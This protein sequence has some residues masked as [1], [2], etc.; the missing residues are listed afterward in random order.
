MESRAHAL[1]AGIFVVLFGCAALFVLWWFGGEHEA[2]RQVTVVS[3]QAIN[4]L[5]PQA[6][7]RYRGVRIGKVN[8]IAF[9]RSR[10]GEIL[11]QLS[12]DDD[13]PLTDKT[14]A[15]LAFQGVT[16][17]AYIQLDDAPG[18]AQ[19][20]SGDSPRITLLPSLISE[21]IDTG[22]DT[23]R[24]VKSVTSR[25]N[26]LLDEENRRRVAQ[27]LNNLEQL[28]GDA[29]RASEKLPDLIARLNRLASDD[30]LARWSSTLAN[31]AD[32]SG[33]A[34]DAMRE[35]RHVATSL[36]AVAERL[37]ATLARLDGEALAS[38]P[39]KVAA[40]ADQ[41]SQAAASVDRVARSL[42]E[43]PDGLIFGKDKR[44]P[45]PGENGFAA[46]GRR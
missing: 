34:G 11:L 39:G 14:V 15:R 2:V 38:A 28:T 17:I 4:G 42:E 6:V 3:R 44:E 8:E 21:G 45:G 40:M 23:L 25:V 33:Q 7:V 30:N 27:S 9:D 19:P 32:A 1:V 13:A 37:D 29:A 18:P 41:V 35:V 31:A 24:E 10:P 46:G 5:N 22:M 43:R 16:G 26:A 20:L 36:R 12:V